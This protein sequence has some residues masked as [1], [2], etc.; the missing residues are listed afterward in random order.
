MQQYAWARTHCY[1]LFFVLFS[2]SSSIQTVD[3][4]DVIILLLSQGL[5]FRWLILIIILIPC[6]RNPLL[7]RRQ[8]ATTISRTAY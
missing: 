4:A 3:G 6:M 5:A 7:R 2:I 8:Q 1:L